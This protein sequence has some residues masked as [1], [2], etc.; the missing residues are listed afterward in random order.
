MKL[1]VN[2]IEDTKTKIPVNSNFHRI[3]QIKTEIAN[4]P[5]EVAICQVE[6]FDMWNDIPD[7]N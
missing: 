7:N 3:E 4:C 2:K 6:V 1:K 5:K